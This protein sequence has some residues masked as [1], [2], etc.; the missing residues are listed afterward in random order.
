MGQL[1]LTNI[2]IFHKKKKKSI[3]ISWWL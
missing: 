3:S 1:F 2:A